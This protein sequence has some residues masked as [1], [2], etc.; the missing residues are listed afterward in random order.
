KRRHQHRKHHPCFS[1]R[2][3]APAPTPSLRQ[4]TPRRPLPPR[5]PPVLTLRLVPLERLSVSAVNICYPVLRSLM[6]LTRE[7]AQLMSAS[8]ID[9]TL[10]RLA[11]EILEKTKDLDKLA[12]IGIR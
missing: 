12:F 1:S 4:P 8:E 3:A 11:H 5:R 2:P 7:K 6:S 9:R 10:V